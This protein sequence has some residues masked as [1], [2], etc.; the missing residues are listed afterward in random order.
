MAEVVGRNVNELAIATRENALT[1][2]GSFD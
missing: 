1:I 2:F